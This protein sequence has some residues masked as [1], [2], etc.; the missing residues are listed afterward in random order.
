MGLLLS[1]IDFGLSGSFVDMFSF[2]SIFWFNCAESW[3]LSVV[4]FVESLR[5]L[6]FAVV[7]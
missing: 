1:E 2:A 4:L 7:V 3:A 6:T 5:N